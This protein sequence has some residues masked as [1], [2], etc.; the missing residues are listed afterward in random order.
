MGRIHSTGGFWLLVGA[1]LL[2]APLSLMVWFLLAC[3]VHELGHFLAICFLGGRIEGFRLTGLGAVM[4]PRGMF[5]YREECL[6]ALAGPAASL[7]LAL[8]AAPFSQTLAGVSLALGVFNLMPLGPLDG[9]RVLGA[10]V[11][12]LAGPDQGE[13]VCRLADRVT[14][15][16]MAGAGLWLVLHGGSFTL[17]LFS[18]GLVL[19]ETKASL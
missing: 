12:R 4:T 6:I 1:L 11:S 19:M 9:G 3:A 7:I 2:A 15:L 18:V 8:L 10:V 5:G 16:V 13:G 14:A 17:L